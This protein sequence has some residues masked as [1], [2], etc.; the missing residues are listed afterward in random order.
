MADASL[1]VNNGGFNPALIAAFGRY[2]EA[3]AL[4]DSA[5]VPE[6]RRLGVRF[7]VLA[8]KCRRLVP[9]FKD[10]IAAFGPKGFDR[11]AVILAFSGASA[12]GVGYPYPDY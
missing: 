5:P 11:L 9:T 1:H 4:I 7:V 2:D 10:D 6:E 3:I 8:E 12:L